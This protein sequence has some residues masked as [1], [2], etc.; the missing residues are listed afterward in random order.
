MA[1]EEK[2][3]PRW[4]RAEGY[5]SVSRRDVI[6]EKFEIV[7][8]KPD[9]Q[10]LRCV[11]IPSWVEAEWNKPEDERCE[12]MEKEGVAVYV[13]RD[14]FGIAMMSQ[15]RFNERFGDDSDNLFIGWNEVPDYEID[16]EDTDRDETSE[17]DEGDQADG[18]ETGDEGKGETA[19]GSSGETAHG[20][21]SEKENKGEKQVEVRKEMLKRRE[22]K[23]RTFLESMPYTVLALM[24]EEQ[25]PLTKNAIIAAL[26]IH[27]IENGLGPGNLIR[28]E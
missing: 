19:H 7:P 9:A 6:V 16:W 26:V 25:A 24:M 18:S 5:Y 13:V 1:V 15:E 10:E 21:S 23:L 27:S 17:E 4:L 28:T 20:S 2:K 8:D 12:K 3:T 11:E 22:D 14:I